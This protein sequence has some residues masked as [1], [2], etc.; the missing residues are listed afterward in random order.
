M[1]PPASGRLP[2]KPPRPD[3]RSGSQQIPAYPTQ[4]L[5]ANSGPSDKQA[6]AGA[7]SRSV[8]TFVHN[9]LPSVA[10][11]AIAGPVLA[12]DAGRLIRSNQGPKT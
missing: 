7:P 4:D 11:D 1:L 10:A 8:E 9:H 6:A 3:R 5:A 2:D 12:A